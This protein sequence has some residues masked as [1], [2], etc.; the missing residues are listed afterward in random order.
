MPS[1]S[2]DVR[3]EQRRVLEKKLELRLAKLAAEGVSK[4]KTVSDAIVKNLKSK[5]KETN[6]RIAAID[7]NAAKIQEMKLAKEKK[8]AEKDAPKAAPV[9]PEKEAKPK[10][11]AAGDKEPKKKGEA[12]EGEAAKKPKKKKEDTPAA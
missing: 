6:V 5:I 8:A 3:I 2:K 11:K 7:K 4:E 12:G 9:A 1:K 10:K